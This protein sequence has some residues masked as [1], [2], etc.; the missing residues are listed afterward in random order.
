MSV[1]S[2]HVGDIVHCR[3]RSGF[4]IHVNTALVQWY[5]KKQSKVETSVFTAEFTAIEQSIDAL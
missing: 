3:L 2:D 1:H 4:L 5:S